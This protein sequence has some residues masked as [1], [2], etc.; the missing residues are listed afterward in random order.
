MNRN[1]TIDRFRGIVIFSMI[2][3]Q[4]MANFAGLGGASTIS[5]HAPDADAYYM[6]PNLAVADIVAPM[7]ILAI[8]LTYLPSLRRR[9]EKDGRKTAIIHFLKRNLMIIGI[10]VVMNG[11]NDILDGHMEGFLNL[12][13]VIPTAVVLV[14][15]IVILVLKAVKLKKIS[16]PLGKFLSWF[17]TA[18]GVYG[19]GVALVNAVLLVA[20]KTGDSFGHWLVLHHIGFAGL[21]A[22]P[23]ALIKGKYE[24]IIRLAG[25]FAL[26]GLFGLFHSGDLPNDMF[27]N[28]R[29]LVDC[30]ADGGFIGGF[31]WGAMLIIYLA[32][33]DIYM[34]NKKLFFGAVA[35]YGVVTAALVA[36]IIMTLPEGAGWIGANSTFMAINKP[37]VSPSFVIVTVFI[38]LLAFTITELF[39]FYKLSFD[40]FMWWGKNP[41]L[42]YCLE[43]GLVGGITV[44]GEDF[45]KEASAPVAIAIV[46]AMA[47]LLTAIAYICNKKKIIIKI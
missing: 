12:S 42:M 16:A 4:F 43:F 5:H 34:K 2:I 7:F 33:S 36:G 29:D 3:F 23:F 44:A 47:I 30:V 25:G 24:N 20:G 27:A 18:F 40:P 19:V 39:S 37:S 8:G 9:I 1:N 17:V 26:L 41:I 38:S 22:L 21:V 14:L 15:S 32:F 46:A 11:I 28:N 10:G 6:L 35:L 45:F 31:A 13:F